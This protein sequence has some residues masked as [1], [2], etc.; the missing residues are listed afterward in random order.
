MALVRTP[1]MPPRFATFQVPLEFNKLDLKD[2]LKNA[3]NVDTLKIRS[4]VEQQQPTRNLRFGKMGY[5]PLRRP[6]SKKRMM[7]E[8]AEP[9][10]WPP[11]P[12][13]VN[14]KYTL[15]YLVLKVINHK[16]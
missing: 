11:R 12:D 3:Y 6:K 5:G 8:L 4:Y 9:F 2:Y 15:A 1:F 7:V 14:K 16:Y 10:V 13:D